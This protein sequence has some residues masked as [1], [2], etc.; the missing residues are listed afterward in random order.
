V[1]A[2]DADAARCAVPLEA[3]RAQ[4]AMSRAAQQSNRK[5]VDCIAVVLRIASERV[6]LRLNVPPLA[7]ATR[8]STAAACSSGA[9]G[10]SVTVDPAAHLQPDAADTASEGSSENDCTGTQFHWE[11]LGIS[12]GWDQHFDLLCESLNMPSFRV[13]LETLALPRLALPCSVLPCHTTAGLSHVHATCAAPCLMGACA[14]QATLATP[15]S[16]PVMLCSPWRLLLAFHTRRLYPRT[17]S[18]P[19]AGPAQLTAPHW[20]SSLRPGRWS[21]HASSH[22]SAQAGS[23]QCW[24]PVPHGLRSFHRAASRLLTEQPTRPAQQA[25]SPAWLQS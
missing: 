12:I 6:V 3:E 24:P 18:A 14:L 19:A 4:Q 20:S 15:E 16:K 8:R 17:W 25:L 10:D 11:V 7:A 5:A 2:A 23:R 21:R 1:H 22:P 13:D 9:A